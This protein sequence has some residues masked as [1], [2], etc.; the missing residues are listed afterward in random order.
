MGKSTRNCV[1]V[2]GVIAE[3]VIAPLGPVSD[4][5]PGAKVAA[6]TAALNDN[7]TELTASL[8]APAGD[9]E[10][11]RNPVGGRFDSVIGTRVT[12]FDSFDSSMAPKGST[13][14]SS[15]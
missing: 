2:S 1:L 12:L 6:S 10:R 13:S 3:T 7:V 5:S 15:Q 4:T 11:I 9:A 8:N 14:T